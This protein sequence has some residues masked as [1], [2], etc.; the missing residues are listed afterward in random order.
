MSAKVARQR[1]QLWKSIGA[2]VLWLG[3][4]GGNALAAKVTAGR[5]TFPSAPQ[6]QPPALRVTTGNKAVRSPAPNGDLIFLAPIRA[7]SRKLPFSGLP[8][9]EIVEP[10]GQPVWEL[11]LGARDPKT[12]QVEVAMDLFPAR[13]KGQ[14]V[15]VWWQG[16]I[17]PQGFGEGE[18]V[19]VNSHYEPIL[20]VRAPAGLATDFHALHILPNGNVLLLASKL[21]KVNLKP[22]GGPRKGE[23]E[24]ELVVEVNPATGKAVWT[25]NPYG[26][27]PLSASYE[28]MPKPGYPWDPFHLNSL[29]IGPGGNLIVSARN[30]WAV[31]WVS[32]K[33][34]KVFAV[35]GGKQSTFKEQPGSHFAWQ[36]DVHYVPRRGQL[37]TVFDDEA[38]P[39][40]AS[41]SRGLLLALNW[42]NHTVSLVHAYLLPHP[43]LAGSQ[44]SVQVLANGNVFVGWGQLPYLSEYNA[45]GKLLYLASFPG[46]DESYR[47]F[48]GSWRGEPKAPP[49]VVQLP[50]KAGVAVGVSWN[51]ATGVVAWQL[52][53]GESPT[54][55]LP[56]TG[57]VRRS[58]FETVLRSPRSVAYV[59]VRALGKGNRQLAVS[60][61]L[62]VSKAAA[63]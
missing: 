16:Y 14:P 34:G 29:D 2:M 45:A 24:D 19:F 60:P 51:G 61:P 28:P 8:G 17:T 48:K 41:Q 30:T 52:L 15:L 37:I 36:H 49:A 4:A 6:L 7:Y 12:G 46:S 39:P 10:D 54:K 53:G 42:K 35:L 63:G 27:I 11:P 26:K 9:P 38:A 50:T 43:A 3:L 44:G 22:F 31:Y 40:E 21:V 13:Y 5:W 62:A 59:A 33:T 32:R 1:S 23:I 47:A 58:G 20:H 55:L 57:A 25:W 56:L 18:W